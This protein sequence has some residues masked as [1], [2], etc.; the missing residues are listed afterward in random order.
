M[1]AFRSLSLRVNQC[2]M[3]WY[4]AMSDTEN[5]N[6][7]CDMDLYRYGLIPTLILIYQKSVN[8]IMP[9]LLY[10]EM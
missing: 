5:Y 4:K 2:D 8:N 7:E 6:I 10:L 3:V 1:W 9:N